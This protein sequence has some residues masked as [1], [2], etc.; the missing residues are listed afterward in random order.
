MWEIYGFG[1]AG[2]ILFMTILWSI[3]IVLRNVSIVDLF[4]GFGFVGLSVYYFF[5]G[6]GDPLRKGM[7]LILILIWGLRLSVYLFIRNSGRGE[8]IRYR[9]FRARYGKPYWWISYFQTFILQGLIMWVVS[10]PLMASLVYE[11]AYLFGLLDLL[12]LVFWIIGFVF[13]S[14]GD[15]QLFRFKQ[16]P[17]NE[18]RILQEGLWKYT[19]H[20]NYFGNSLIWVGF[21]LISISAGLIW[22]FFG[23]ITMNFL[24]IRVSGVRTLDAVMKDRNPEYALYIQNTSG[25]IP[26]KHKKKNPDEC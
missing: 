13:E 10:A 1:L 2:I 21:G 5:M 6:E 23:T 24:L 17:E 16:D 26:W 12:G 19:R 4:W 25:F 9:N 14:V 18:G 20:P 7:V 11:E 22:P 8:D 15:A 3:S